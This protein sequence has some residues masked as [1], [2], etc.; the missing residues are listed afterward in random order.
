MLPAIEAAVIE[1][2]RRLG[3]DPELA[4]RTVEHA[5]NQVAARVEQLRKDEVAGREQLRRLNMEMA[6]AAN[7][8]EMTAASTQPAL[9]PQ[10]VQF[11]PNNWIWNAVDQGT[12]AGYPT[13]SSSQTAQG[14]T[15]GVAGSTGAPGANG[16]SGIIPR[17]SR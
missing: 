13:T 5:R 16:T 1:A 2:I 9:K 10:S 15:N 3:S 11:T 12:T 6:C 8:P 4:R 17:I 14:G 7:L